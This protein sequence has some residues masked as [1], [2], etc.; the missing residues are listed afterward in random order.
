MWC[1]VRCSVES[2]LRTDCVVLCGVKDL[3]MAL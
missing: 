2:V 1:V 3:N